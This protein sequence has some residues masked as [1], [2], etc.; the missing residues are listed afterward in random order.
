MIALADLVCGIF[1]SCGENLLRGA[2]ALEESVYFLQGDSAISSIRIHRLLSL[3]DGSALCLDSTDEVPDRIFHIGPV[4]G[5]LLEARAC[6][7]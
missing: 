5:D 1:G 7:G 6:N 3:F 2:I 4:D